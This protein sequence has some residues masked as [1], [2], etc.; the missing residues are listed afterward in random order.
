MA[1]PPIEVQV[2]GQSIWSD[3]ISRDLIESG[4]LKR[5]VE[6]GGI[7]GVT[8]NPSIFQKAI[9][10]T[11]DYNDVIQA[12]QDEDAHTIYETLAVRDIQDAA[13]ILRPV[14]NDTD[15]VDGY[16][17]LEVSP[18]LANSTEG[19]LEEARKLFARVDR[20]NV[21]IKIPGTEAGVPAIESAIAEGINVNVT[22]LFSV[23]NYEQVAE[24]YIKGLEQRMEKGEDV[25]NVASVASFFLSR[26]DVAVDKIL[27]NNI[28]AAQGRELGR[29]SANRKLLGKAA[30]ANATL[31]YNSYQRLFEGDR[32]ATLRDAGAAVQRPLWAS[33][34]TKNP[35][36]PDTMYIDELIGQNTVN[37][38]PPKTYDAFADHGTVA[39]TL[40]GDTAASH[41]IMDQL[42]ELGIHMEKITTQLQ[43]DGVEKFIDAFETL[44]NQVE[45]KRVALKTGIMERQK[46]ALGIYREK[47]DA[48]LDTLAK[49]HVNERI[50]NKDATVWKDNPPIM[51]KI[52]NRLGWLDVRE[53]IDR[54]RLSAFQSTIKGEFEHVVLLGMGG[55]SLAP[56]VLFKTFGNAEGFPDLRVL[57]ST[58]PA[59]VAAIRDA[60]NLEKTVFIVASKSGGTIETLSFYRTFWEL[61]GG[62]GDQ[63]IAIT[64]PGS[65]LEAIATE[66][67]FRDLFLNPADIGGRYSALSY[68]GM[69]PAA[70]LGID[71]DQF[72]HY[73]DNM[74]E[75]IGSQIPTRQHSGLWLG[76]VIGRL[77]IEGRD[78]LMLF[79]SDGV[80]SFGDWAEQ[81]IAESTGKE[82]KGV[83]PVANAFIG[84]PHD[85]GSDRV[86]TYLKL[87]GD[88]SNDEMDEG[89]R[90]LREAGHPR[91]TLILPNKYALAGEF[92]RWEYATAIAG[93]MLEINP[94]DEPNVSEAKAATNELLSHFEAHGALPTQEPTMSSDNVQLFIEAKTLAPLNE[95]V[96]SHNFDANSLVELL[97]AQVLGTEAGDYF[98]LLTYAPTTPETT[99]KLEEIQRRLR[100]NT[101]RAVTYGY[102]PRYLHSTG[103]LHKGGPNNGVFFQF[104]N[105]PSEDIAIPEAPYGYDVL[106]AAQ[107]AGDMQALANHTRRAVRIH[108]TGDSIDPALDLLLAA[109]DFVAARRQ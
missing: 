102:G 80:S 52:V 76:A 81:L 48:T 101:R 83:L 93:L 19:T 29:V 20:P 58:H 107:A 43:A 51:E 75:A 46:T 88:P 84:K 13:D 32:F 18:L 26:I 17:S 55:S 105:T 53:T 109:L 5:L 14:Y 99:T 66:N 24:A 61:T 73:A 67:N 42:L 104:T 41:D 50:W 33:T 72:W 40:P 3:N 103:Q 39:Q 36:Y 22:L 87:E 54:E 47:V 106:V 56:E 98:A 34:G 8:S 35:N 68:F 30:I 71:L 86:F 31:A 91:I 27:E 79:A 45:A 69:V 92:I 65:K 78:K 89:I 28:R 15:G 1:I 100:H 85:Y 4:E 64:D 2:H 60:V 63:F 37:T 7:M 70:L 6:E 10:G 77:A 95:M 62:S 90:I 16:V 82:G 108:A 9:G 12:H 57:D 59:Q 97:A 96:A 21:M 25:T 49:D 94:F 74:Y 11:N 44:I 23:E 38:V